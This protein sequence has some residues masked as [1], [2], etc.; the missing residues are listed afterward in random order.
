MTTYHDFGL[1]PV[2]VFSAGAIEAVLWLPFDEARNPSVTYHHRVSLHRTE[3][4]SA[5]ATRTIAVLLAPDELSGAILALQKVHR[6]LIHLRG[7][8]SGVLSMFDSG[9][10]LL[11][12]AATR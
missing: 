11:E 12:A 4:S 9:L 5:R 7:Q 2:R 1:V 10:D 6:F 3:H 8:N